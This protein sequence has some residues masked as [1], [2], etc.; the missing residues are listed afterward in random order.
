M[1]WV[2]EHPWLAALIILGGGFLLFLI[3]RRRGSGSGGATGSG[4]GGVYVAGPSDAATQADAQLQALQIQTQAQLQ[5]IGVQSQTQLAMAQLGADVSKLN[6]AA[7]AQSTDIGTAAQLQYGLA[8]VNAQVALANI[9]ATLQMHTIDAI[10]G[11][12]QGSAATVPAPVSSAATPAPSIIT[13]AGPMTP[14]TVTP[15][16][17]G[18]IVKGVMPPN[19]IPPGGSMTPGGSVPDV[20]PGGTQLVP[21]YNVIPVGAWPNVADVNTNTQDQINWE[22]QTVN[23]NRENNRAQC[24]ANAELSRGYPN[25]DSLIAACNAGYG[26]G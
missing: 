24:F 20:I 25:Y 5:G 13:Q 1:G 17:Y 3:L 12:Y 19:F 14:V 26:G 7:T 4:G 23:A 21:N 8:T 6:I 2:R 18:N 10:V 22:N 15:P 9:D 16:V 11:A